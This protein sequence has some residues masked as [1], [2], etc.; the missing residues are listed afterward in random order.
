MQDWPI[1]AIRNWQEFDSLVA[2]LAMRGFGPDRHYVFRGQSQASWTLRSSFARMLVDRGLDSLEVSTVEGM[3]RQ[4]FQRHAGLHLD[5]E[6]LVRDGS[7][8]DWTALMQHHYAPTRLLD[9]TYSPYVAAYFACR[10]DLDED[11]ALWCVS[12]PHVNNHY[13]GS[14][15]LYGNDEAIEECFHWGLGVDDPSKQRVLF[16]IPHRHNHRT[17]QQQAVLSL[18]SNP[19]A[20][21][22]GLISSAFKVRHD[23]DRRPLFL[24]IAISASLKREFVVQL[25]AM[26]I[27]AATLFPGLDGL[28]TAL[29]DLTGST[30]DDYLR[31]I[32]ETREWSSRHPP[33]R[34]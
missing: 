20:D 9:W 34:H 30:T 19:L 3:I 12:A 15:L 14:S 16:N 5:V 17:S 1:H 33:D 27:T 28:G 31:V 32:A 21:Q 6:R 23:E 4:E 29:R 7:V 13:D 11:G 22:D 10:S 24:K 25:R 26:N 2:P 8:W 18:C